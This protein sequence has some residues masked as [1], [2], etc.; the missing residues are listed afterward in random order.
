MWKLGV[1]SYRNA[2]PLYQPLADRGEVEVVRVVP[3]KL[4]ALLDAGEVDAALMPIV[5][6]LRGHGDGLVSDAC[7]GADSFVRSVLLFSKVPVEEVR[8]VAADTSSHSS[9]ALIRVL[10]RDLYH[11]E[12][13]F[14]DAAPDL[15]S[16][17]AQADA[18]LLIGDPALAAYQNPGNLHVLDLATAWKELTGLPFVFAAWT[19]RQGLTAN[20]KADL[21]QLLSTARDEGLTLIPQLA[22]AHAHDEV[23]TAPVIES[24]LSEAIKFRLEPP[25]RQA[26][27]EFGRRLAR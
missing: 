18:A 16:M 3:A 26:I 11:L 13:C 1:V 20:E 12:P 8:T 27:E 6:H 7:I 17:L 24:Y 21:W 19:A 2:L 23:L 25:Y 22:A 15:E 9:V 4:A 10:L 14:Q 5:D